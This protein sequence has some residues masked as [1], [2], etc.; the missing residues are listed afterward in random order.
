VDTADH[1]G[2]GRLVYLAYFNVAQFV[3]SFD[4]DK[5]RTF[6]FDSTFSGKCEVVAHG[7]QTGTIVEFKYFHGEKV[8]SYDYLVPTK[9]KEA[10]LREFFPAF[11]ARNAAGR[12][13]SIHIHLD[14]VTPNPEYNFVTSSVSLSL[15]DLPILK[16]SSIQDPTLDFFQTI[17]IYYSVV[18]DLT[19]EKSLVTSIC[20]D[21]RAVSCELIP[22]ESVPSGHQLAFFFMSDFFIG[23]TN[24][25]R[26][27][28]ELPDQVT[29]KNLKTTLRR[30]VGRLIAEEIPAV[31]QENIKTTSDLEQKFPHLSGYY[32]KDTAGL[33]VR[34]V[35]LD[36]AQKVFFNEQKKLLECETLDEARYEK[37]LELS[38]RALMEYVLYRARII[39]RLRATNTDNSEEDI[40]RIIVP[41]KRTLRSEEWVED[42]YNNNVWM[43]DDKY[44]SYDT[45]LSDQRMSQLMERIGGETVQDD[46]RPDLA[47][48][49]SGDPDTNPKVSVVIVELKKRGVELAKK[50]EV[51]SQL[52]QR[53]RKL[54]R[55]YPDKIERIWFYGITDIDDEFRV[56]LKE[57]QFKELFS[58]G[59]LFYKQMP[60]ITTD[61][62]NPFLVDLFVMT[63]EALI[64]DAESRNAT[65][66]RI[67]RAR[68]ASFISSSS[69]PA[70]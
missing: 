56:S 49:F 46:T 22:L 29:E 57:D 28:L 31:V 1:K 41:M 36:E 58:H 39:E 30:E 9:V 6:Q 62:N 63:F 17:D 32:P 33:I 68:I 3:S 12:Q 21:G 43:L 64:N 61:E 60:V 53:A 11:F 18:Q 51:V 25:S 50:E 47:I 19:K 55:Y 45:V 8:K 38:A 4:G 5:C 14:V 54:L 13:L 59:Q 23:K 70:V 26:Q 66:I 42:A 24:T 10:I 69:Y 2:L 67:L 15:K 7:A 65:F 34:S 27:K 20:V 37:A 44:M 35:A 52:R 40:H 16:K 48:V